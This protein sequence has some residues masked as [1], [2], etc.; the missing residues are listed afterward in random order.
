MQAF[1]TKGVESI[2]LILL[3]Q[4]QKKKGGG[5]WIDLVNPLR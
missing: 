4:C 1:R 5:G 3:H 2:M